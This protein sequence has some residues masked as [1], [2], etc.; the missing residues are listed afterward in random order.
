M[1]WTISGFGS[2]IADTLGARNAFTFA[3]ENARVESSDTSTVSNPSTLTYRDLGYADD[4]AVVTC[5]NATLMGAMT[6]TIQI[7]E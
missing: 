7:G 4:N 1:V 5:L 6:S 3:A 2:G